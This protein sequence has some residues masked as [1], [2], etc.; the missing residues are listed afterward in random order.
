MGSTAILLLLLLFIVYA[1]YSIPI[2]F[3]FNSYC[4]DLAAATGRVDELNDARGIDDGGNSAFERAQWRSLLVGDFS[5]LSDP[6]L[7]ARAAILSAK[8][9]RSF[10]FA[11]VLV[12]T[13]PAMIAL[14]P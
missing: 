13:F 7:Q 5:D 1:G 8:V 6:D 14:F 12:V 9:R 3:Q 2:H 4:R 10:I 11:V